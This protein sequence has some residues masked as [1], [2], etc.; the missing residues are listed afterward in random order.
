[1]EFRIKNIRLT[2]DSP[3][4]Q[5]DISEQGSTDVIVYLESGRKFIASFF[6]YSN[7]LEMKAH[8]RNDGDYLN[9]S[10]FWDRN[11]VLVENC[12]LH[13]IEPVVKDLIDEGNFP[14]AFR[15]L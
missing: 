14:I 1:M 3:N 13:S 5:T 8:H 10:Y 12:S 11:M 9:G 6:T 2:A 15:E 7:I 4:A